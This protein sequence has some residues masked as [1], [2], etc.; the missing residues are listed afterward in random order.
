MALSLEDPAHPDNTGNE[1]DRELV[2]RV[3]VGD[4]SAF[5]EL[6]Q[7]HNRALC[8]FL[9]R[10][11]GDDELG[12]DIA[13]DTFLKAFDKMISQVEE[14]L[15]FK[16]W[17]YRIAI[18]KAN[19][20]WRRKKIIHWIPWPKKDLTEFAFYEDGSSLEAQNDMAENNWKNIFIAGPEEKVVE[21]DLVRMALAQVSSKYRAALILEIVEELPQREIAILLNVSER[22]VR[23]YVEHGYRELSAAYHRLSNEQDHDG[24]RRSF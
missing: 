14:I 18:N 1:V 10:Y 2:A 21:A 22:S 3:Q 5:G 19:D 11:V 13:Q 4:E 8:T 17:L 7:R 12:R 9:A 6:F 16:S 20:H 23:R 15:Y 24:K